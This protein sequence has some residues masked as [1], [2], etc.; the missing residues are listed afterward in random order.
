MPESCAVNLLEG[1]GIG[2]QFGIL[3]NGARMSAVPAGWRVSYN[4]NGSTTSRFYAASQF[5]QMIGRLEG[6]EKITT[7][8]N[9]DWSVSGLL[10]SLQDNFVTELFYVQ[11]DIENRLLSLTIKDLNSAKKLFEKGLSNGDCEK[12]ITNLLNK[13]GELDGTNNPLITNNIRELFQ[14][15]ESQKRGGFTFTN[16]RTV[17]AKDYLEENSVR[18]KPLQSGARGYSFR[19]LDSRG[20]NAYVYVF[21]HYVSIASYS[22][23]TPEYGAYDSFS[24]LIHELAHVAGSKTTYTDDQLHQAAKSLGGDSLDDYTMKHCAPSRIANQGKSK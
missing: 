5:D 1:L 9:N 16:D 7:V 19:G 14:K 17:V 22:P 18:P 2:G 13:L 23:F 3:E 24:S 20:S 10:S 21:N 12:A 4:S 6:D 8:F 11:I 15:V